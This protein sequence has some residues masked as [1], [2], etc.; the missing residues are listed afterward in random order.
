MRNK[1]NKN[2]AADKPAG[3]SEGFWL[4][5]QRGWLLKV[6]TVLVVVS[7]F[8]T[9]LWQ[10]PTIAQKFVDDYFK[11][12]A[13]SDP[14]DED[15]DGLSNEEEAAHKTD[16]SSRDTDGDGLSD[17]DEVNIYKTDPTKVDTDGDGYPDQM[18]IFTGHDPLRPAGVVQGKT[19]SAD[20]V[21]NYDSAGLD[22]IDSL[23]NGAEGTTSTMSLQDFGVGSFND[24]ASLYGTGYTSE[25]I[26]ILD[27]DLRIIEVA[28]E[29]AKP[30]LD[31]YIKDCTG[32]GLEIFSGDPEAAAAV[33]LDFKTG[34]QGQ[35]NV[36]N[37]PAE[38]AA[39][40]TD[41]LLNVEIPRPAV[42][43]H[44]KFLETLLLS[45]SLMRGLQRLDNG[46]STEPLSLL[47]Q[48]NRLEEVGAEAEQ[49]LERLSNKYELNLSSDFF[50][51]T[52]ESSD[53]EI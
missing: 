2:S 10:H 45:E 1:K 36:L 17:G 4:E 40:F 31:K 42:V 35:F 41:N 43:L 39:L 38:A 6:I 26:N 53:I 21:E 14:N 8:I 19:T 29:E 13:L 27:S 20:R 52:G 18:E 34:M 48:M 50:S 33:I 23:L 51:G 9:I 47:A 24:L 25:Q 46:S 37:R 28:D 11:E 30:L 44:K 12:E 16:P 49:E 32:A 15:G 22:S 3:I 5:K 7:V